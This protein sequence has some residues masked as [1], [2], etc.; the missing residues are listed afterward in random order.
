MGLYVYYGLLCE[1]SQEA[2]VPALLWKGRLIN[3]DAGR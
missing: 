1:N 2:N 3:S